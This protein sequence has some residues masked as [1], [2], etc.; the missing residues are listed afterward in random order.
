MSLI[1]SPTLLLYTSNPPLKLCSGEPSG[2]A[3]QFT[4]A[5]YTIQQWVIQTSRHLCDSRE[6]EL[7]NFIA[8]ISR[9]SL[10]MKQN[11]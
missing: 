9:I 6:Y 8:M 11:T 5:H 3:V 2:A 10:R 1:L 7:P 4:T